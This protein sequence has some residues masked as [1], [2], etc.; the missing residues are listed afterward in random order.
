MVFSEHSKIQLNQLNAYKYTK[1]KTP[2]A[3]KY[4]IAHTLCLDRDTT[5]CQDSTESFLA[6][7]HGQ[8][9]KNTWPTEIFHHKL[10]LDCFT[11]PHNRDNLKNKSHQSSYQIKQ[12]DALSWQMSLYFPSIKE[13]EK[14]LLQDYK[15]GTQHSQLLMYLLHPIVSHLKSTI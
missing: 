10:V 14:A 12:V 11:A 4:P 3:R 2:C 13:G 8:C 1:I 6:L 7:K 15:S 9:N 5:S